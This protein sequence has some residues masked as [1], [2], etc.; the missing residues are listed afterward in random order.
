MAKPG[1]NTNVQ[2]AMCRLLVRFRDTVCAKS[3]AEAE[4]FAKVNA[5]MNSGKASGGGE[6][7]KDR[8]VKWTAAMLAEAEKKKEIGDRSK[9]TKLTGEAAKMLKGYV[10]DDGEALGF[11]VA[12]RVSYGAYLEFANS[13]KHAILRPTIEHLRANFFAAAR[14]VFGGNK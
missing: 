13:G 5:D 10:I 3:A 14:E 11:G 2:A 8:P 7:E 4:Q 1:N 9:W 12:H 6:Q